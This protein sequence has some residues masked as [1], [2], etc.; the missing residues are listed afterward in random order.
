MALGELEHALT[1]HGHR[2]ADVGLVLVTHQHHDH[3]GLAGMVAERSGGEIACLAPLADLLARFD[4]ATTADDDFQVEVMLLNGVP[5][6]TALTLRDISRAFR[7]FGAGADVRRRLDDGEEI[8]LA[9]RRLRVVHV[10]GHSPTDT[11]FVDEEHRVAFAG[12]HLI[13]R[14]SSNPVIH[15]PLSGAADPARRAP[16]LA[17]YLASLR[18]TAELDLDVVLPGHGEPIRDHRTLIA[19]RL[20]HHDER[21]EQIARLV[22]EGPRTAHDISRAIWGDVALRQAYLTLCEV[23][24]HTDLL[25][26]EG[27]IE[28]RRRGGVV[29]FARG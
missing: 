29:V 20:R 4:A 14:V 19:E 7:R 23:L 1:E 17:A 13:A 9:R 21:K 3:I 11:L 6:E 28:E 16:A 15:R 5:E 24:G 27:R 10:P 25:V 22:A 26:A 12:D 2:L 18:R 8:S